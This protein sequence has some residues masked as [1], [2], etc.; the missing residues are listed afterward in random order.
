MRVGKIKKLKVKYNIQ[1]VSPEMSVA[2]KTKTVLKQI[3]FENYINALKTN[4][5]T[6]RYLKELEILGG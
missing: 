2:E 5:D 6:E 4:K 1:D 3:A